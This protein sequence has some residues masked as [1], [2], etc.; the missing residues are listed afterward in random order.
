[1]SVNVPNRSPAETRDR[2]RRTEPVRCP[3]IVRRRF[4]GSDTVASV[5]GLAA[6]LIAVCGTPWFRGGVDA[7]A[8]GFL[9]STGIVATLA[10]SVVAFRRPTVRWSRP[11]VAL[12]AVVVIWV[13]YAWVQT[14]PIM[15]GPRGLENLVQAAIESQHGADPGYAGTSADRFAL[16]VL[17]R[18]TARGAVIAS[19]GLAIIVAGAV[20]FDRRRR[21]AIG[22]AAL[23]GGGVLI[24]LWAIVQQAGGRV[25]ILP[26]VA[27]TVGGVALGP[28]HYKNAGAAWLII[29]MT[30]ASVQLVRRVDRDDPRNPIRG[31]RFDL[32]DLSYGLSLA[33]ILV[34]IAISGSRTAWLAAIVNALSVA[35]L[36]GID[37]RRGRTD[38][39]PTTPRSVLIGVAGLLFLGVAGLLSAGV[40]RGFRK[41]LSHL[42]PRTIRG[43]RRWD[44]W[45]ESWQ[46]SSAY[47]PWGSG[48]STYRFATL[49]EQV[50]PRS[51]WFRYAHNQFL[52]TYYESGLIGSALLL[53]GIIAVTVMA[54]RAAGSG[55]PA[56]RQTGWTVAAT[57][58]G[59]LLLATMDYVWINPANWVLGCLMVGCLAGSVS[60]AGSGTEQ[61]RI[62]EGQQRSILV[63]LPFLV[64]RAGV[65]ACFGLLAVAS[66]TCVRFLDERS[67]L[68]RTELPDGR[69]PTRRESDAAVAALDEAIGRHP[70]S[71]DL[72]V[73]RGD[74]RVASWRRE[75]KRTI[76]CTWEQSRPLTLATMSSP[77]IIDGTLGPEPR[78]DLRS[79]SDDYAE[80]LRLHP[81]RSR[82]HLRMAATSLWLDRDPTPWCELALRTSR[83]D[84]DASFLTGWAFIAAG[85]DARALDAWGQSLAISMRHAETIFTAGRNHYPPVLV[86]TR[87]V[88]ARRV[89]WTRD[90]VASERNRSGP[91]AVRLAGHLADHW[92]ARPEIDHSDHAIASG[93]RRATGDLYSEGGRYADAAE[94]FRSAIRAK[95]GD[96]QIKVRLIETLIAAGETRQALDQAILARAAHMG[97]RRFD[98]LLS[99][100]RRSIAE[101]PSGSRTPRR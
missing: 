3:E 61:R 35:A 85:K 65:A 57:M 51:S 52:E 26:G 89:W 17:P 7:W 86:G 63:N 15:R 99:T 2:S 92:A 84:A 20:L 30:V 18:R 25:S 11:A 71:P 23:T 72:R 69:P 1:M 83:C 37:R 32:H 4:H 79:A 97:D 24:T 100:V 36:V 93:V 82:W 78:R 53:A 66:P 19:V 70:R 12:V 56:T 29:A 68:T 74:W 14:I 98:H 45:A 34:G 38:F 6:L 8:D 87:L 9:L 91:S 73:R 49:P 5:I 64:P 62:K 55:R 80:A 101:R 48:H 77:T 96:P 81:F 43:D 95:P 39:R 16:S 90:L 75:V 54:I 13:L 40:G 76:D 44:H 58:P 50:E 46:T 10:A 59:V 67:V 21:R 60:K 41:R 33:L 31:N 28:F 42:S 22:F 94:Q 47:W 27:D 88:P